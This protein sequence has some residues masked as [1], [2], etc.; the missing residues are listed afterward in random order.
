MPYRFSFD[1][2]TITTAALLERGNFSK[3]TGPGVD[4][5][6]HYSAVAP[7]QSI[8]TYGGVDVVAM[9]LI[10]GQSYTFDID[11]GTGGASYID[12]QLDVIN[13][14]GTLVATSDNPT[15]TI[16]DPYL[17]FTAQVSGTY[18]VAVHHADNDY[19]NGSFKFEGTGGNT[20]DYSLVISTP[21]LPYAYTLTNYSES[22]TYSD[23]AQTVRA[24]GGNDTISLRGG[25][26]IGLGGDGDDRLYGGTGSDE[27][28]GGN[29]YDRLYGDSGDDVLNGGTGNDVLYGGSERDSVNGGAGNDLLYG[30]TGNDIVWGDSGND[31]LYGDSGND[32][33][34]GGTGID[35]LT[36]GLG[37]DTFH[38]MPGEANYDAYGFNEDRIQ[39]FYYDDVIDLSDMA[40]GT[41]GWRGSYGFTGAN[42]VRVV[43]QSDGS[44]SVQV[45]LD[46]DS[47][48]EQ[49][50]LVRT[51]GNFS[52]ISSDF[53]L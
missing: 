49:C 38:F 46:T 1:T 15:S 47:T 36:G 39:D 29:G 31:H 35:T 22:R 19:I 41:L 21:V 13:Q 50:I 8:S 25:N 24:M 23:Y 7:Y 11:N 51:S 4:N 16:R 53:I 10:A 34:R 17:T 12:L 40:W 3:G 26:D 9:T 6:N 43:R 5:P 45:N 52:L 33:L 27:L 30:G 32:I 48:P 28:S 2:S 18:Y 14:A 42:Q 20:G 44:Q 37:A